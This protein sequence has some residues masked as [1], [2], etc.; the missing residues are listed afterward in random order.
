MRPVSGSGFSQTRSGFNRTWRDQACRVQEHPDSRVQPTN[1]P[2]ARNSL[3]TTTASEISFVLAHTIMEEP[4]AIRIYN[5]YCAAFFRVQKLARLIALSLRD[6]SRICCMDR[7]ARQD[8][9]DSLL[10]IC[11]SQYGDRQHGS[12]GLAHCAG[13]QYVSTDAFAGPLWVSAPME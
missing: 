10:A 6:K 4:A 3:K 7:L 8:G 12:R 11:R 1:R 2:L 9:S 13:Q 5:M